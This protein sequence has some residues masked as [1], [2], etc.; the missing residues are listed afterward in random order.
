[1]AIYEYS[2]G[3]FPTSPV[4][5]DVLNINGTAY[6]YNGSAWEVN[7]ATTINYEYTATIGQTTF[8]GN[9]DNGTALTYSSSKVHVFLSGVLLDPSDYT[10]TTGT[11]IV[12]AA[13]IAAAD[14]FVQIVSF[15]VIEVPAGGGGADLYAANED[16]PVAQPSAVG[17]NSIA[18]GQ[19]TIA[20]TSNSHENAIAIGGSAT[21]SQ[22][23]KANNN[24]AMA[25]GVSY[26]GS[27]EASGEGSMAI[28]T[29]ATTAS[30]DGSTAIGGKAQA[31]GEKSVAL[32]DA[33]AG[34]AN[35]FAAC[36]NNN[37]TSYGA[38]GLRSF[39]FG[40]NT[41][42]NGSNSVSLGYNNSAGSNYTLALGG[43]ASVSGSYAAQIG[44]ARGYA[45]GTGK[46]VMGYGALCSNGY[47]QQGFLVLGGRTAD[48]TLSVL[49][50]DSSMQGVGTAS[51]SNQ[52]KVES[53]GAIAFEG[54]I[55]ARG[56]GS[57]NDTDAG[58]WRI[59]GLIT[60]E[61]TAASTNLV[62]S[63]ITV[64][65][66]SSGL[67]N[68][69]L[70]ADTSNSSLNVSVTGLAGKNV[71]WVCTLRTSETVYNQY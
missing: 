22:P 23:V 17:K 47:A 45:N 54:L 39:A 20:G 58:A 36:I 32:G 64:I 40:E 52:L 51:S 65:S 31:T 14:D 67:G 15:G 9:D 50:S 46:I 25:I 33:R 21:S 7:N 19:N 43:Y 70:T 62:N 16:T 63:A 60:K 26:Y 35:S 8:T 10:A 42:A 30:G 38:K 3:G 2:S 13:P 66:N 49:V 48:A 57:A 68:P 61:S 41:T 59:E 6:K 28:G 69:T 37:S 56:Q 29:G 53:Y 4:T 1:M 5:D 18:I 12:L 44:G 34:G 71:K 24:H 55:V 11:S 27:V